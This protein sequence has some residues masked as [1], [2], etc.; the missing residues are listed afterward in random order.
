MLRLPTAAGNSA[1]ALQVAVIVSPSGVEV[2]F[3]LGAGSTE[4]GT[5]EVRERYAVA[6]DAAKDRLSDLPEVNR[7][8]L[9]VALRNWDL[10]KR[11]RLASG[12]TDFD[13]LDDWLE[14]AGS[15]DGNGASISRNL[16]PSRI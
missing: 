16:T 11:W 3:C 5:P 10:R 1:F 12:T 8:E 9:S 4:G 7:T 2:C 15:A 14:F 6:L 13:S